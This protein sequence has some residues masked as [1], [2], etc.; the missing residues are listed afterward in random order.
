[1]LRGLMKVAA[2][3]G[4]GY[5]WKKFRNRGD[6]HDKYGRSSTL[7]SPTRRRDP[8]FGPERRITMRDRRVG[9]PES[10]AGVGYG[11][12]TGAPIGASAGVSGGSSFGTAG[13]SSSYSTGAGSGAGT[14]SLAGSGTSGMTGGG[15]VGSS[16]IRSDLG[17]SSRETPDR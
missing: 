9:M 5:A 3:A 16:S 1:M 10:T 2:I 17:A 8:A 13:S 14:G 7:A 4:A 11:A 6:S 12:S 15:S